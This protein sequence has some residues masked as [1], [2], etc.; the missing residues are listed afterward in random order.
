MERV[1]QNSLI[2]CIHAGNVSVFF[3]AGDLDMHRFWDD[4][5]GAGLVPLKR[6][7][8]KSAW[9]YGK[10]C[11]SETFSTIEWDA[12]SFPTKLARGRGGVFPGLGDG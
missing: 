10:Y 8:M 9:Q 6:D 3:S 2:I 5:L 12:F 7:R 11:T 1:I 4:N